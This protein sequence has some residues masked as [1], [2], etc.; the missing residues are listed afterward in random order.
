MVINVRK[1]IISVILA[2]VMVL[3]C[4]APAFAAEKKSGKYDYNG[5]PFVLVRGMDFNGLGAENQT[6]KFSLGM[7][8][9][10]YPGYT[11][12]QNSNIAN[13]PSIDEKG[14]VINLVVEIYL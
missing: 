4:A 1:R 7:R 11:S 8:I 12:E 14:T 3:G 10:A 2:L 9:G 5:Y 13:F 6:E